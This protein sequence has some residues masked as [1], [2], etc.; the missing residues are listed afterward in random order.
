MKKTP[1]CTESNC[2]MSMVAGLGVKSLNV[3]KE[4]H[5]VW[6]CPACGLT[7]TPYESA[8]LTDWAKAWLRQAGLTEPQMD[9]G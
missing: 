6:R 3:P 8:S 9:N 5:I 7:F 2:G 1:T 4:Y